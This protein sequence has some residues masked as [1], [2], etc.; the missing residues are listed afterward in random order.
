VRLIHTVLILGLLAASCSSGTTDAASTASGAG[1][2][3]VAADTDSVPEE[4][5][6]TE[7]A[8]TSS[9]APA[10]TEEQPTTTSPPVESLPDACVEDRAAQVGLQTEALESGGNE[11]RYQFTVPSTYDGTPLPVVLDFHPIGFTGPVQAQISGF[12]DLA[13][14]EGFL[15]V[16]PTGPV[17][18][19][20]DRNVWE[21]AQFDEAG[22]D[23]VAFV[24]DLLDQLGA[25]VCL[26]RDR[27]YAIGMS[28]G[29][30]FTS[31]L[32]C[33][34]SEHLAAA[35]SVAGVTHDDACSPERSIPYMAF[36]G[37]ADTTIPFDGSGQST[38][39]GAELLGDFFTQVMPEEFDEFAVDAGCTESV[40][41]PV[42]EKVNV[43]TWPE[44]PVELA[45]YTIS[46]GGHTWP[47]S[48]LFISID[49]ENTNVDIDATA[50]AWE[51]FERHSR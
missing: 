50:L 49:P 40:D 19:N 8:P 14:T 35:V 33:R 5:T 23:D 10:T 1:A 21:L 13:E 18:S 17:G 42:S 36:H 34:F 12:A 47:G 25:D 15:A 11:Y 16:Q 38:L 2:T 28:S 51:F 32:V 48:E 22:R 30:L 6:S 20:D 24:G 4:T 29:A 44:C 27:V 46:D 26:D 43:R 37:T 7:S 31:N 3:T 9:E 39:D 45:F 41:T